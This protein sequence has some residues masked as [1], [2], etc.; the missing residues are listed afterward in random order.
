[1]FGF[2]GEKNIPVLTHLFLDIYFSGT[3]RQKINRRRNENNF[4][5]IK[6][7]AGGIKIR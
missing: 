6:G 2:G 7:V 5:N 4:K 1:M 3:K